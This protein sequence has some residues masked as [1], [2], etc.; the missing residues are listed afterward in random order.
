MQQGDHTALSLRPGGGVRGARII[1]SA[2]TSSALASSDHSILRPHFL[3][4]HCLPLFRVFD[5]EK[6]T[7]YVLD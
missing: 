3:K 2:F 4:V 7:Y 5:I 6:N 1:S